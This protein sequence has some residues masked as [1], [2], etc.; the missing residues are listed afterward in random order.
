MLWSL[1]KIYILFAENFKAKIN[2]IFS[3]LKR[4]FSLWFGKKRRSERRRHE[5]IL[6]KVLVQRNCEYRQCTTQEL[7]FQCIDDRPGRDL[8]RV[9]KRSPIAQPHTLGLRRGYSDGKAIGNT[10]GLRRRL[11]LHWRISLLQNYAERLA[12]LKQV[13]IFKVLA[14]P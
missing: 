14:R 9:L 8:F 2:T 6:R 11:H 12:R 10:T 13:P 3:V 5:N 1:W 7:S 4:L